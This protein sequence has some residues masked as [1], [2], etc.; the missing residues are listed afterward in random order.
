MQHTHVFGVCL[1]SIAITLAT[2]NS[3]SQCAEPASVA[4]TVA[5]MNEAGTR[6]NDADFG[7]LIN[8]LPDRREITKKDFDK[9]NAEIW[10]SVESESGVEI[11]VRDL[12]LHFLTRH[13]KKAASALLKQIRD[14][15]QKSKADRDAPWTAE[16][17]D[18]MFLCMSALIEIR[19]RGLQSNDIIPETQ[20][21]LTSNG[22]SDKR[23]LGATECSN[24]E[25]E[26]TV[27]CIDHREKR[28]APFQ[29]PDGKIHLT[30]RNMVPLAMAIAE[31]VEK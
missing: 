28:F 5:Q 10:S 23:I 2:A 31:S 11:A 26:S 9:R 3:I 8:A 13:S 29:S 12:A 7:L 6:G 1:L 30:R 20:V 4:Q 18:R 19:S 25:I 24:H 16:D 14:F 27:G 15:E 17:D 21:L 22:K